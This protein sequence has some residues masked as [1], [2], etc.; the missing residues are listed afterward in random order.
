M[1]NRTTTAITSSGT[2]AKKILTGSVAAGAL[3]LAP[4]AAASPIHECGVY[5]ISSYVG[6][7]NITTRSVR[8]DNALYRLTH[9]IYNQA[10]R[11]DLHSFYWRG[12]SVRIQTTPFAGTVLYDVRST[13][14][15]GRVVRY[16]IYFE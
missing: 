12:W 13:A 10:I 11:H 9:Q 4:A 8:C 1:I 15:R 14:S 16:Q 5:T 7:N 6:I 3:A 2:T